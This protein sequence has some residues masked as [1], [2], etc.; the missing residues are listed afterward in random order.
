MSPE[1]SVSIDKPEPIKKLGI[2]AMSSNILKNAKEQEDIREARRGQW[3]GEPSWVASHERS[4]PL[5]IPPLLEL[6]TLSG[7][8]LR[9]AFSLGY[10][11]PTTMTQRQNELYRLATRKEEAAAARSF[12]AKLNKAQLKDS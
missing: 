6:D 11:T 7:P 2:W 12:V 10:L 8:E 3:V 1:S 4:S 9:A 5:P